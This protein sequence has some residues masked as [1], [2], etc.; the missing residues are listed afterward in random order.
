MIILQL[1][2]SF[3]ISLSRFNCCI[4]VSI[5][6]PSVSTTNKQ[7]HL[8]I[9]SGWR[10]AVTHI[11]CDARAFIKNRS[12]YVQHLNWII[13]TATTKYEPSFFLFSPNWKYD[14][15]F[16]YLLV[17]LTFDIFV[18]IT[19]PNVWNFN[20]KKQGHVSKIKRSLS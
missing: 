2:N 9:S 6:Q 8:R 17:F 4:F 15:S 18:S 7:E 19:Q 1:I 14:Y 11:Y 16:L 3:R 12:Y 20:T 13:E 5:T 10:T